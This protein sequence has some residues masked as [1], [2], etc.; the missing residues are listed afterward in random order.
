MSSKTE[1][2][3]SVATFL[4]NIL[5]THVILYLYGCAKF[6]DGQRDVTFKV[7]RVFPSPKKLS[8]N[9]SSTRNQD[10]IHLNFCYTIATVLAMCQFGFHNF[11]FTPLILH[12]LHLFSA[13]VFCEDVTTF[14]F[15]L[16]QLG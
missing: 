2:F 10:K 16:S 15:L 11:I 4:F 3:L 6:K 5:C 14:V 12:E 13:T 8:L 7:F 9:S 1:C